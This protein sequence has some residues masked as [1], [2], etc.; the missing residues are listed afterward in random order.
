MIKKIFIIL[1]ITIISLHTYSFAND[2]NLNCDSAILIEASS[3]KILYSKEAEKKLYPASLTKILTAILVIENCDLSDIATVSYT[4]IS[5]IT[6]DY[7]TASLQLGEQLTIEQLLNILLIHSAN[8]VA[9]VLAEHIAGSIESF[10]TMMNTKAVELGCK[11]TNFVNPSGIHNINHYSTAYDLALIAKY[12]MNNE[13]F[14]SIVAKPNYSIPATNKYS[15]RAYTNYNEMI[16]N[17]NNSTGI[18][19]GYTTLAGSCLAAAVK[20]EDLEL[21]SIVLKCPRET[22]NMNYRYQDTETLMDFGFNNYTVTKVVSENTFIKQ[23]NMPDENKT[24]DLY[25][26]DN[27]YGLIKKNDNNENFE[28]N[29]TLKNNLQIPIKKGEVVGTISYIVD[30]TTYSSEL[31]SGNNIYIPQNITIIYRMLLVVI[32]L[33]LFYWIISKKYKSKKTYFINNIR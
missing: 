22:K 23:L 9:N 25:V 8:D 15:G 14:R 10:S 13:T 31:I 11:N 4:S 32:I 16:R 1:I 17:N 5:S 2:L 30:G 29:I 28:N 6:N 3:G 26:K 12:A 19:T 21:I 7:V 33:I 20:R 18:K 27:I 24:L